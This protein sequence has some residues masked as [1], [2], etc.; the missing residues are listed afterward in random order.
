MQNPL[1]PSTASKNDD[2]TYDVLIRATVSVEGLM[3]A[4]TNLLGMPGP[5]TGQLPM[6]IDG[7][8]M[9]GFTVASQL[10][11]KRSLGAHVTF[12]YVQVFTNG[13]TTAA[14]RDPGE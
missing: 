9:V 4:Q 3:D 10:V 11:G 13:G 1:D 14:S 6:L 2:G 12:E 7:G 8:H 5:E